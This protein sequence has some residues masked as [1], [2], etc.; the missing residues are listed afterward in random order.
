MPN[1]WRFSLR[2]SSSF[3]LI[4]MIAVLLGVYCYFQRRVQ[5]FSYWKDSL[6]SVGCRLSIREA[7]NGMGPLGLQLY[8]VTDVGVNDWSP[9]NE[10]KIV[11]G[12][13]AL[14]TVTHLSVEGQGFSENSLK[15]LQDV[16]QLQEV[17]FRN[18]DVRDFDA[19]PPCV[20]RNVRG[21]LIESANSETKSLAALGDCRKL[22]RLHL[23]S[24]NFNSRCEW[25]KQL[26]DLE[27]ISLHESTGVSNVIPCLK[28]RSLRNF[29]ANNSDLQDASLA[30]VA[31]FPALRMC[32]IEDTPITDRGLE[33]LRGHSSLEILDVS[34]TNITEESIRLFES[35]P[36]LRELGL[37]GT[38]ISQTAINEFQSR[39]PDV[40]IND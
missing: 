32:I 30:E 16:P 6:E 36:S 19:L 40:T 27:T 12:L 23:V 24:L 1:S 9:E 17:S 4:A 25:M 14:G 39:R 13:N 21:L 10:Q 7:G 35:L 20:R 8:E 22:N 15:R 2:L 28:S 26:T 34:H 29:L 33:Y 37:R 11:D 18:V 3:I 5:V 31:R 38:Q